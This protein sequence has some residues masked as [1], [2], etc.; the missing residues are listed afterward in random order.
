MKVDFN[1][2]S[3]HSLEE[4]NLINNEDLE[5]VELYKE[6]KQPENYYLDEK[7][8]KSEY[9]SSC[10]LSN[11]H[12][13]Q[14]K[15]FCSELFMFTN[16][17]K[18]DRQYDIVYIGAA[19]GNHLVLLA[20]LFPK[21]IFHLYDSENFDKRLEKVKNVKIYQKYFDSNDV[22]LWKGKDIVLI[23]D[24][25]TLTYNPSDNDD[26]GRVIN[27]KN[28]WKDMTMQQ[29]WIEVLKPIVSL[30][31]FRLPFAYDFI[32]KEGK[33]RNYLNGKVCLQ[34]YNKPT[35]SET[36][37]LVT[38]IEHKDWDLKDYEEKLYY[39]NCVTRN[40]NR[41][42]NPIDGSKNFIYGKRGLFND[43]DSTYFSVIVL[44]YMKK[45]MV[46]FTYNDFKRTMDVIL[47]RIT[48]KSTNIIL[49]KAGF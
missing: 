23:S 41:Y 16:F 14:L 28:V 27:E 7:S 13:G 21:L 49:K 11:V 39:H 1:K 3:S 36:R 10:I 20:D 25:R 2:G 32:M 8:H 44:E 17:L 33:T 31:K 26:D 18:K 22:E 40:K 4:L 9:N 29:S 45:Y 30:I 19:P 42:F 24:I 12:W 15:L 38:E 34:V 6:F 48:N 47:D 43:F 37:L 35:S 46:V 5:D